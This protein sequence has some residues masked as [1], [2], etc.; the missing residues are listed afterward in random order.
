[1]IARDPGLSQIDS[2]FAK[3]KNA[4]R[5][6]R[7][8]RISPRNRRV[9][10]TGETADSSHGFSDE[11][12]YAAELARDLD[13]NDPLIGQGIDRFCT[14]ILQHGFTPEPDTG[15]KG[16][17]AII[18][19]KWKEYTS[20]KQACDV[21]G[22][23]DFQFLS[24]LALRDSIVAG[25]IFGL[26]LKTGQIQLLE[27]YRCRSPLTKSIGD[28][29]N[30]I[31]GVEINEDRRRVRYYFTKDPI[32]LGETVSL[33]DLTP[34]EA[35][36]SSSSKRV[37]H[38]WHPKRSTATRG[39][40]KLIASIPYAEMHEDVQIAR[41]IQQK[42]VSAH[43]WVRERQL[44]FELPEG[45]SETYSR[46]YDPTVGSWRSVGNVQA[47]SVYT[48]YPGERFFAQSANVP[49]PTFFDH[50]RSIQQFM[51]LTLDMPL[52]LF[53]LDASETN[54][55][56]WRGAMEQS[57]MRFKQFQNWFSRCAWHAP[58]YQWKLRQWTNPKSGLADRSLARVRNTIGN[59]IFRHEW[60]LPSFPYIQ[61]EV[62][63]Q[64]DIDAL[65]NCLVSPRMQQQAL[66]RTW[67]RTFSEII[68]DR[69][70]AISAAMVSAEKLNQQF[71]NSLVPVKWTD[72][73]T[74][75]LPRGT[76]VSFSLDSQ[77][78]SQ[79]NPANGPKANSSK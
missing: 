21:Q 51:S 78:Q 71:P 2:E 36:D 76:S 56:G 10:R 5:A 68:E 9:N 14:N 52:I 60:V 7:E 38:V 8:T 20:E 66:G 3:Y 4:F 25:D 47:G 13:E 17:N 16:A 22:E 32:S 43:V 1:M 6:T 54:F 34:I 24:W 29:K 31:H 12:Y 26:P 64:V 69:S 39:V 19:D 18:K 55:S 49:N 35:Y 48:G 27:N 62:E 44:G 65:A 45:A 67:D 40:T 63:Q 73:I 50:A 37:F 30:I 74:F 23:F 53:L 46:E 79:V 58:I 28:R 59:R 77:P 75:P 72:L 33:D 70:A 15:N 41:L 42:A 57:R 61:P 11:I